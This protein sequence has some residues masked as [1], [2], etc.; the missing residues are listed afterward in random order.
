[1]WG[2]VATS[3][4]TIEERIKVVEVMARAMDPPA[5]FDVETS[6]VPSSLAMRR[7]DKS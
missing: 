2:L 6:V 7:V 1:M 3:F 5:V 4:V